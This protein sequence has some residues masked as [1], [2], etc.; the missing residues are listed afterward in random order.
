MIHVNLR[1]P[2]LLLCGMSLLPFAAAATGDDAKDQFAK[3]VKPLLESKCFECHSSKA[4]ELKGNL[5]LE[6]LDDILKG[7]DSGPAIKAGD[8]KDSLLLK[9]IRYEIED[10]Q[11]PPSGKLDD[12]EIELIEAWVKSLGK[13]K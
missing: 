11:M 12:E 2:R 4:D 6:S 13:K 10:M 8:V 3:K 9:A 5:K 1:I 7:G